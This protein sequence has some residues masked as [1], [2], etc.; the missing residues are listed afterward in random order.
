MERISDGFD[1][2]GNPEGRAFDLGGGNE[3]RILGERILFYHCPVPD[4]P[5]AEAELRRMM[6]ERGFHMDIRHAPRGGGCDLSAGLLS[7]YT[8]LWYLS[9]SSPT[10]SVSQTQMIVDYVR[11]GNGLAI[12]A[13]NEPFYAD[14]NILA[15]ALIGSR[16]SGNKMAD[17]VMVPGP[18]RSRGHFVEHQLTQ[19]VNNLYEGITI[20]T[21]H[22]APAVTLLGQS[23]DGQFCLGCFESEGRRVVLDTGFTK[24]YPDRLHRS[25]GLGR[26]L[27]NIAFWLAK[28]S[29]DVEY[30]LLTSGREEIATIGRGA[31]SPEYPFPVAKPA[32]AM[33]LLQWDGAATLRLSLRAPDGTVASH[34]SS[35]SPIR[36]GLQAYTPGTWSAQV[37]GVDTPSARIPYVLKATYTTDVTATQDVSHVD[38]GV[39]AEGQVVMPFYILCDTSGSMAGDL[40]DLAKGLEE[41]HLGLLTEPIVNDLVMMSVITFNDSARTLVPLAAPENITLPTLPAATGLTNYSAAFREFHRAFEADRARLKGKGHR[42]YRPCVYFLTDGEPTDQNYL[43]TFKALLTQEHNPAYPYLCAFGFRDASQATIQKLAHADTGG[44]HKRAQWFIAGQGHSVRQTLAAMVDVIGKSI[45][46]SAQS[47]FGGAPQ[48]VLPKNIP[49]M[50]GG[51]DPA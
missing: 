29:R 31:T 42:I 34:A 8:Q 17:R 48:V 33:C 6:A 39:H 45:L 3:D 13:D 9:G 25:A 5:V 26:Y 15:Q 7:G 21:I 44:P 30:R 43:D 40:P 4:G 1:E 22:D 47:A 38:S 49:G 14:A 20:C 2:F 36:V 27:A 37:T 28:G 12:W 19:G 35:H 18:Q 24:L 51:Q 50:V 46:Q 41:L 11:Q 16:F 32:A 10:L 23:H